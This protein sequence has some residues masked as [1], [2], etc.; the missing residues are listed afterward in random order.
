MGEMIYLKDVV[1][2]DLAREKCAGCGMCIFVCP[3]AVLGLNNGTARIQ[4]RDACMECGACA[5][6]C[7]AD[8]ISVSSG[9]GCA[10]A[11]INSA[12]GRKDSSS[13]C[14]VDS[15]EKPSEQSAENLSGSPSSPLP[16]QTTYLDTKTTFP[17]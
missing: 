10:A 9:V 11:V 16:G 4:D 12:L 8:A 13:C 15:P 7:P 2:L 3:H 6:N 1:T 5:M 14:T 17:L